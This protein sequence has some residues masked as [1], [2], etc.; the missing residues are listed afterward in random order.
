MLN[1][2]SIKLSIQ[3]ELTFTCEGFILFGWGTIGPVVELWF[4]FLYDDDDPDEN[5]GNGFV[6]NW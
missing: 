4:V 2:K 3:I 6:Y 1:Y 5:N